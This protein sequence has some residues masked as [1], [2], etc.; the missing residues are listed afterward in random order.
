MFPA[1]NPVRFVPPFA[2]ANVP[3]N[4]IA[5]EVPD[6]GVKPVV[7]PENVVT[8]VVV[9]NNVPP[10]VG[11]VFVV[12]FVPE[13]LYAAP[14]AKVTATAVVPPDKVN[15]VAFVVGVI[16]KTLVAERISVLFIL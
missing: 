13:R 8:P 2:V 6:A 1:V 16:P 12:P 9:L 3:A 7:P 15:P 4:V 11:K 14:P 10:A 5:P